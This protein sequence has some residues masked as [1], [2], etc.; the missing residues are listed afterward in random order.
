MPKRILYVITKSNWGGAQRYV[1]DL[2][3]AD[4][5]NR[6]DVAVAC[7][8]RGEMYA[9]LSEIGVRVFSIDSLIR[10]MSFFKEIKSFAHL[11]KIFFR[12][13]PQT[14]HLNS[15]KIGILGSIAGKIY[16]LFSKQKAQIIFTAHGWA[17]NEDRNAITKKLIKIAS[18]LTIVLSHKTVVL[19]K[20]EYNQVSNW[21]GCHSKLKI[22]KL[23][24]A[25]IEFYSREHSRKI[26]ADHMNAIISLDS[27]WVITV[28]EL[29]KNKGLKF[30]IEAF[31]K[32]KN[33]PIWIIIGEGEER[34]ILEMQIS[35]TELNDKVFLIGYIENAA[36]LLKAGDVFL[37]PSIKE[38]LPYVL[39]EAEQAGLPIIATSVGG[40]S[41]YFDKNDNLIVKSKD[42]MALCSAISNLTPTMSDKA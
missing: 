42:V 9:R 1:F 25:P 28:A 22:R 12:F 10:D 30:G 17:F 7:G 41:E 14:I 37:L 40:I 26:I 24:I 2:S 33:P 18:Y 4:K 32:I 3:A 36:Q 21:P 5:K 29:H 23:E 20:F 31:A 38:G 39:L 13:K 19:S 34:E 35:K 15:S 6:D 8:G 16:N 11:L 27:K